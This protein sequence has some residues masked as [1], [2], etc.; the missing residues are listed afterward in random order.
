MNNDLYSVRCLFCHPTRKSEDEDFLYEERI[1]LWRAESFE[2]AHRMAEKEARQYAEE[3][4][5]SFLKS[6]D[7]F[8]LFERAMESGIEVFST[9]RGSNLQPQNYERTFCVTGRDRLKPLYGPGDEKGARG[10]R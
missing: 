3:A 1:T 10:D 6:T 4:K 8:H 7:S 2:E 5:C 9:M